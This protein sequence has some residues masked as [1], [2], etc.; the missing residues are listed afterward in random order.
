MAVV[1]NGENVGIAIPSEAPTLITKEITENGTYNASDEGAD[2]YS[3]VSVNVASTGGVNGLQWKCDNMKSLDY[4]FYE[5]T[6]TN[7]DGAFEGLDTSNVTSFKETFAYTSLTTVPT[8]DISSAY[9]LS[10]TFRSCG[11]IKEASLKNMHKINQCTD[12]TYAFNGCTQLKAITGL[13]LTYVK[14]LDLTFYQCYSLVEFIHPES[15]SCTSFGSAFARCSRLETVIL[16]T[17]ASTNFST[18]FNGCTNLTNLTLKTIK[19]NIAIGSGTSYGQ[20]LTLDSLINTIKELWDYS[21]GTTTYKLTMGTTNLEKIADVYVKLIDVTDE[22][23]ADDPYI[24]NKKPCVVCESTD[25][26][27][28]TI[29]EYATSKMWQLA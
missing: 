11:T 24:A 6:L 21:S 26:G 8:L 7:V 14:T 4:E 9:K 15:S 28:M 23:I 17:S 13:D 1:F 20:L 25:E 29:T 10:S 5:C 19:K 12:L 18:M 2:G 3:S 22:M 16:D 27:A